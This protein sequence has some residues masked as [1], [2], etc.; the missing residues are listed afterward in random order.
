M[1]LQAM[2]WVLDECDADVAGQR[3][4][5]L[6]LANF[7]YDGTPPFKAFPSVGSLANAARM[8]ERNTRYSL[9]SLEEGGY[10][11][12]VGTSEYG[13][14]VYEFG[15]GANLAP[16]QPTAPEPRYTNERILHLHGSGAIQDQ[17]QSQ[18][19]PLDLNSAQQEVLKT[20]RAIADSR[21]MPPPRVD[22]VLKA[23]SAYPE[24]DHVEEAASLEAWAANP[25]KVFANINSTYRSWLRRAN[26]RRPS[27]EE[28]DE[29][30]RRKDVLQDMKRR[31]GW[32]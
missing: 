7:S 16:R 17:N 23:M 20:L 10:I 18:I 32:D 25:K 29:K 6:A 5:L 14:Y 11:T 8:S 15:G 26:E 19:A 28:V 9:R 3:L 4:V 2:V 24:V 13:T 1:S 30:Q 22:L 21:S 31:M 27:A 12:R